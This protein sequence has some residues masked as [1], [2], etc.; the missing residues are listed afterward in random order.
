MT[1]NIDALVK[2]YENLTGYEDTTTD[3]FNGASSFYLLPNGKFLNC[4]AD[5]GCRCDDHRIIFG[6]TKL[7]AN[8]WDKLHRNYKLVRLVVECNIALVKKYQRLTEEQIRAI[9]E[10]GFEIERY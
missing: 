1:R 10:I 2:R 9:E 3:Y 5:C 4:L 8:D 7:E 6:A